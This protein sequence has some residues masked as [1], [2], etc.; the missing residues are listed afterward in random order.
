MDKE[1]DYKH[2]YEILLSVLKDPRLV[3]VNML[4]GVIAPPTF[5]MFIAFYGEKYN[6]LDAANLE[7][8]RLR[9]EAAQLRDELALYSDGEYGK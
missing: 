6:D 7:V 5:D 9:D 2:E 3:Y 1:L 4:R 8:A